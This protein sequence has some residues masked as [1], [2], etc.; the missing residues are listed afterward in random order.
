M[1]REL[2]LRLVLTLNV[3]LAVALVVV[4]FVAHSL[5]LFAA[6]GDTVTDVAAVLLSLVA[7]RLARRS[8]TAQR[9][10]GYHRSTILAA[11]T[12]AAAI[13]VVSVVIV[14]EGIRRLQHTPTVHGG[15]M[16]VVAGIA[17]LVNIGAA[18]VLGGDDD[19]N[20]RAVML[21]SVG[22]AAANT[23]VAVSGAVILVTGGLEWLD[24][25]VSIA[26]ALVIAIRAVRLLKQTADVLL[27]STP[28]GLELDELASAI[29]AVEGVDAVHD[30]H[31]W[32]LSSEVRALSAHLVLSGHPTL[33]EAQVVGDR[34]RST[35]GPRFGI[36]HA[37]LELECE[38][39]AQ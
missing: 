15:P 35:I 24:P 23:G 21:D 8:P 20:M 1:T 7:V 30:I 9:S 10:F 2:R 37:T 16:L 29:T 36:A 3:A 4:G 27:E 6:A 26:I 18:L 11:Q 38:A 12:N 28:A 32:S 39:C 33:E 25:A 31:A 5:G 14:V 13:L 34:V 22:D 17:A 19:L